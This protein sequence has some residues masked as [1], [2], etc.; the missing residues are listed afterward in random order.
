M[1]NIDIIRAWKDEEYRASLTDAERAQ[2][3]ANPAGLIELEENELRAIAGAGTHGGCH[4][5][6]YPFCCR[7]A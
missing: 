5:V 1:P 3:P 2:L 4:T 6:T 7:T